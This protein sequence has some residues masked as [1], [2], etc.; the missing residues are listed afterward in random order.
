MIRENCIPEI[1]ESVIFLFNFLKKKRYTNK[2]FYKFL[3]HL[4]EITHTDYILL[5]PGI[6]YPYKPDF[7]VSQLTTNS[8]KSSFKFNN[9]YVYIY[10]F[11]HPAQFKRVI[12]LRTTKFSKKEQEFLKTLFSFWDYVN[13]E[14]KQKDRLKKYV[15]VDV[16]TGLYNRYF[17]ENVIPRELKKVERY[18][19]P[20]S[21]L[22]LDIDDFKYV[23]DIY[24]HDV[25]DKVLKIIGKLF[26]ENIRKTDIPIRYGGDEFLI[27]LPF[28]RKDDAIKLAK[29]I[30]ENIRDEIGKKIGINVTLSISV[31]EVKHES[32]LSKILKELDDL[33][34]F[35]KEKGKNTIVS[36]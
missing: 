8:K 32:N 35:A 19:Q 14:R 23:N 1:E 13:F 28:T 33:L 7:D 30:K 6:N 24:G 34:Y 12:I 5:Y 17:L 11:K 10:K 4:K 21:V 20:L 31:L 18:N 22:F 15:Y 26:R 3:N 36:Q 27:F 2:D 9:Y 29:K 16:L 25:G